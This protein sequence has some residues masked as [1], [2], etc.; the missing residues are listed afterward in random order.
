[1]KDEKE[2]VKEEHQ[3]DTD[4]E[5]ELRSRGMLPTRG[6]N[7]Q[8]PIRP[9]R[10]YSKPTN[11]GKDRRYVGLAKSSRKTMMGLKLSRLVK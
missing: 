4:F 9:E 10:N 1:M 11:K 5:N 7:R 3:T 6:K 2:I 8:H